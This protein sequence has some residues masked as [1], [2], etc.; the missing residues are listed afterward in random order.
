MT[1]EF[2]WRPALLALAVVAVWGVNFAVIKVALGELPPLLFAALRFTFAVF[3]LI[4]FVKRPAVRWSQLA[5]Y[6]L[7]IGLGQF[8]LLF[9]AVDGLISP[10]LASLLLQVQVF[11]TIGMV[12]RGTG[13]RLAGVQWVALVMAA[14]GIGI[15]VAHVGGSTT[16]LGVGLCLTAAFCWA[17]A[18]I[19]NRSIGQVNM[20][21][22]IVWSSVF[23]VPPLY[24]LAFAF[25][26][27]DRI[28]EAIG[29]AGAGT[30]TAVAYQ[31][32]GNTMFGYGAWGWLLAR[33]PASSVAPMSLLVP[34]F[35]M[36][37]AA[38]WLGEPLEPWK[39]AAAALIIGGL[40]VN[41]LG[42]K[43]F[44]RLSAAPEG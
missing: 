15:I 12:M 35:G 16:I 14:V 6:G 43:V 38:V 1:Q 30:W 39:L 10:G 36:G 34:V 41:L 19:V 29:H 22:F 40:A 3:P 27:S 44:R 17:S 42:P 33:Y 24:A 28:V 23:A 32:I 13:E 11:F 18:N 31:A 7:F 9:I 25:E 20:L 8:G 5:R 21:G 2:G 4:L 37:T 26:G